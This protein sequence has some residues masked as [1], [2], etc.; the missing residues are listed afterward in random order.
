MDAGVDAGTLAKVSGERSRIYLTDTGEVRVPVDLSAAPP[1][2]LVLEGGTFVTYEGEGRADGTFTV[3]NVPAGPYYLRVDPTF[4]VV[5]DSR[6][7]DLSAPALGRPDPMTQPADAGAAEMVFEL[8]N[9]RSWQATDSIT[10]FSSNANVPRFRLTPTITNTATSG[11][12]TYTV[13]A[14]QP[15]IDSSQGDRVLLTQ[16]ASRT[17][18]LEGT[19]ETLPYRSVSHAVE[20]PTPFQMRIAEK[21]TISAA[22]SELTPLEAPLHWDI[23]AYKNLAASVNPRATVVTQLLVFDILPRPLTYGYFT[24]VP[25]LVEI[26]QAPTVDE[27]RTTLTYANPYPAS[28]NPI[29]VMESRYQVLYTLPGTTTPG[30]VFASISDADTVAAFTSREIAPPFGPVGNPRIEGMDAFQPVTLTTPTP[31]LTW[32]PPS[33]SPDMHYIIF[34]HQLS[35]QGTATVSR[36]VGSVRTNNPRVRL[37]PGLMTSGNTYVI[38]FDSNTTPGMDITEQPF[39]LTVPITGSQALSDIITVQ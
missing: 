5:T 12:F 27:M 11:S 26:A 30:A 38:V 33:S 4:F 10:L 35:V 23:L 22:M 32:T 37:P 31:E 28:W 16:L 7:V 14:G 29:G 6:E 8:S 17:A 1:Q 19:S 9:L 20:A 18:T 34:V 2:A 25:R 36:L 24:S 15:L 39:R 21:Q 3:P 13:R